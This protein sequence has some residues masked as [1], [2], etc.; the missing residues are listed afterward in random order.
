MQ[1]EIVL[2]PDPEDGGYVAQCPALPGTCSEGE[3]KEEALENIN[4]AIQAYIGS[5]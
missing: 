1:Y 2:K 5:L 3:T 4:E